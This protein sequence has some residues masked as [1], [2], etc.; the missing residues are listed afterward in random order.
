MG[1]EKETKMEKQD[2]NQCCLCG[3]EIDGWGNNPAP[4]V[5]WD[6]DESRCCNDCNGELVIPARAVWNK[7]C[8]TQA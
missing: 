6:E 7:L 5:S 4:L 3:D 1:K 8:D 2:A